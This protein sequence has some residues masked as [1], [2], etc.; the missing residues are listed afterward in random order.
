[1]NIPEHI[2]SALTDEQK[3]RVEAA[4][5]PTGSSKRRMVS[6]VQRISLQPDR[7]RSVSYWILFSQIAHHLQFRY[8]FISVHK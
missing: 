7:T 5:T 8:K 1:M 6:Q 3:K 2:L 4:K